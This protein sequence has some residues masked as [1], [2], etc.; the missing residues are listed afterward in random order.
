[1]KEE[2]V[3]CID[4]SANILIILGLP[5]IRLL[6]GLSFQRL[7]CSTDYNI[8]KGF[9]FISSLYAIEYSSLNI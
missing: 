4:A 3:T 9:V 8:G 2:L 1:M 5:I 7:K 6:L